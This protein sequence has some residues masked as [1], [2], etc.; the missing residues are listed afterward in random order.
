MLRRS[1]IVLL[2]LVGWAA[3]SASLAFA[4]SADSYDPSWYDTDAPHVRIAVVE[5]GVYRVTGDALADALP[6]GT[7]L[8]AID[9]ATL[10]LIENGTEIPI[11]VRG[12]DDAQLDPG[13]A[14]TFVGQRNRGTD[15][16][17]AYNYV[18]DAQ[19]SRDRSLYTDTTYY[20]LTWGGA[21]GLR[22]DEATSTPT[23]AP[24]ATLRDT[25]RDERE[26]YYYFGRA[27]ENGD[28]RYTESEGYFWHRFRHNRE[29]TL[30]FEHTVDLSDLDAS[31][32]ALTLTVRLDAE[33]PSCHRVAIQ[34]ELQQDGGGTA[35]ETLV[36]D[37]WTGY[38]RNT[39]TATV[40]PSR[41]PAE[42]LPLRIRSFNTTF[43]GTNCQ[44]PSTTP[45][46]VLLD[47][48]EVA[49]PRTLT[50]TAGRPD[51]QRFVAPR[52]TPYTFTLTGHS[53][54]SVTVY[55]S[56]ARQYTVPVA[57][58]TATVADTPTTPGI[59][60]W[61]VGAS[62]ERT[63]AAVLPDASSNWSDASAHGADYLILTTAALEPGA[64]ALADYRNAQDGYAVEVARVQDVFD[65]FDYG[66]P[67]PIAIRRFVRASQS[68]DPAPEFLT[69]YGDAQYP[70]YL[71]VEDPR[72]EWN[73][74]S[75]GFSP[76]DGWFAMQVDGPSDWTEQVAV[77]RIPV[78]SV[79]QGNLF[80]D[81]LQAYEN[82]P[83]AP[84]PKRMLLLA[85]GT[86]QI[87]QNSLQFYSNRWGTI[88]S[89]TVAAVNGEQVPVY[90]GADTLR[91]YKRVDDALDNSFQDSLAVDL[92]RGAGWLNYFG[93]SA[94]QTWE[95]VTD[96][97]AEFDNAGR[98]P[99]VV[100]LGCRTGA[101]AGDRFS[102]KSLPSLAEQLVVGTIDENNQP[103]PGSMNGGIAHFG[104]SALGNRIP[105]ANIN[106]EIIE[107]VFVD[108]MRVLGEAIRV[109]K[110]DVAG[111]F[112]NSNLYVKHLLQYG[113]I[114]DP[115]TRIALPSEPDLAV[116][117]RQI[118]I[119]P[120]APQP[121]DELTVTVDLQN[122]GLIP[123]DSVD[124]RLTWTRP[125]GSTEP[126]TRRISAFAREASLTFT[127]SLDETTLGTNTFRVTADP[128]DEYVE[129]SE[130]NN[131][132]EQ[133]TTVISTG[134]AL[135]SPVDQAA[136]PS[137]TPTLRVNVFRQTQE[138]V[139]VTA[140]LDTVPSFD[141]PAL[142]EQQQTVTSALAAWTLDTPLI[143]GETYYWRAR[144]T[145]PITSEWRVSRFTVQSNAAAGWSQQ[146]RLFEANESEKVT[147]T[148]GDGWS[149][150]T[151]DRAILATAERGS[152]A[153]RGQISID[154]TERYLNAGLGFGLVVLDGQTG[155]VKGAGNFCTYTVSPNLINETRCTGAVDEAAAVEALE[156][157]LQSVPET[158]DHVFVRTR[159]LGRTG[160][161]SIPDEVV[162]LF[163]GLGE[164]SP[165]SPYTEA[166]DTLSYADVWLLH[167]R[168]GDPA[169]SE[170]RVIDAGTADSDDREIVYR[171]DLPFKQPAGTTTTPLIGPATVW[172]SASW[173]ATAPTP[174]GRVRVEVLDAS[175][176]TVLAEQM[177]E[178]GTLSLSEL[179]PSSH[180][181]VRLRAVLADTTE[182]QAPALQSW[183]VAYTG[184]PEIALDVGP[185]QAISDSLREG[186]P[187]N[188]TLPI[189]NLGSVPTNDVF[190]EYRWTDPNNA[191][192]TSDIDTLSIAAFD[193]TETSA[194][195]PTANRAGANLL[196]LLA[197]TDTPE[198]IQFNNTAV[199]NFTVVGDESA[200]S[201]QVLANGR[202]LPETP[203]SLDNLQDPSLP[204]VSAEPTME[205]LVADEN[206]FLQIQDTSFVDVFL[207]GGLPEEGPQVVSDF[208]QIP[209]GS[210][211]LTFEPPADDGPNE[212]R[213]LFTPSL[214]PRDST[215]TVKVEARDAQNNE[216]EPYQVS[217]RVQQEQVVRDVYPY[218][219]PMNTHT[220]FA[221]R[222]E[223]GTDAALQDFRL[224]IYTLSGRLIRELDARALEQPLAVGWNKL[225]WNGRDADGNR[226]ATGVYLYRVRV[227]GQDGTFE[228]DVEKVAV[229]R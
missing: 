46:F 50:A 166:L 184:V 16:A 74:P 62:G 180:P 144:T 67:T 170:E 105:S 30:D 98:L 221:F 173:E 29:G 160:S 209:F 186:E 218:P 117:P 80:L 93:H 106:D 24:T 189:H 182:R 130:S 220:T 142:R 91:Y 5:D 214:P 174:T 213:I 135:P 187:A 23:A 192:V 197:R 88:A 194:S 219:N 124:V 9:P 210:A 6:S 200:P 164:S 115:A 193:S 1:L 66:R 121:S 69:I 111:V 138:P 11:D 207:K 72:P 44:D 27:F 163:T 116:A 153:F 158:G 150:D 86:D 42:G 18:P 87:E 84:W 57:N 204:F 104:E 171:E 53:G 183:N 97:P 203:T 35:F 195:I 65:E 185:L 216:V 227:D 78:R 89:D 77:G 33:T 59:V 168:K 82:A 217:F 54:S 10:R 215:Y 154:G 224:R 205:I 139:A 152:G 99:I 13:D 21:A 85:G 212:A 4:Q 81:K 25:L 133:A 226:V 122:V 165:P 125:D 129:A 100:S 151:F 178:S 162:T 136:V 79:A 37:E 94:A 26:T 12:T 96:P 63:P 145:S 140:Q 17:W 52:A 191:T 34:G 92:Q 41:I 20:W 228:G 43:D 7:T 149:L 123:R 181:Y 126:Q 132:A 76:S 119:E 127:F 58:G 206:P 175:G 120:V 141:S 161:A 14:F 15:E 114:G 134:L 32:D 198:R 169:A 202:E 147:W 108:T 159:H 60:Y 118:E 131:V 102:V 208:R 148:L 113:L 28:A 110:S 48:M 49:Y 75:Y 225:R 179:D 146:K 128:T 137:T 45:N 222:V 31:G 211:E 68:W 196:S 223:G 107:R 73:V 36:D 61:A 201:L 112:G 95:I 70:V 3:G 8:D 19:S 47:W 199:R 172:T 22:Y 39:L 51:E 167:A 71:D 177:A 156:S 55:T 56:D 83:P 101:F 229:I 190:V 109:A 176:E 2:W 143:D 103:R 188:V 155:A 90:T 38:S 64:Q 157:F 40:D